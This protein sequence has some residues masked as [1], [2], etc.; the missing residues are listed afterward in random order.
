MQLGLVSNCWKKQLDSGVHLDE[1]IGEAAERRLSVIELRQTCLGLYETQDDFV[2]QAGL[3]SKLAV[4]FPQL[5]F[6]IAIN[7]PFL[8]A[9]FTV[10]E[11]LFQAA[12]QSAFA[13]SGENTPHLR[14]V[15]LS[16]TNEQLGPNDVPFAAKTIAQLAEPLAQLDGV[17]SIEQSRQS[18]PR[19]YDVFRTARQNLGAEANRLKLCYD[20]C[21][22]LTPNDGTDP[23]AVTTA[24]ESNEISLLHFKQRHDGAV[25]DVVANGDVNWQNQLLAVRNINYAG[26]ALFEIA[27]TELIWQRIHE[28][29]DYLARFGLEFAAK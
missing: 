18:W 16:T 29:I 11:P 2:P 24:L 1:L 12:V 7:V 28:S 14:L 5:Q 19:F 17:L 9:G 10:N 20:P 13:V 4:S 8:S 22:L 27:S 23:D 3:L 25:L 26:P 6:N 21:N 15:D